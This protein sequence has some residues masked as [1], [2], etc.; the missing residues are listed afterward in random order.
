MFMMSDTPVVILAGGYGTRLSEY[1][2]KI[3]K[4]L[5][6]ANNKPLIWYIMAHYSKYGF[7]NF[8]ICLGYKGKYIKD[9]FETLFSNK[10]LK[11]ESKWNVKL[12]NTGINSLTGTRLKKIQKEIKTD[13]FLLTYGDG[14]SKINLKKLIQFHIKSKKLITFTAVRPP[15]RFGEVKFISNSN[16]IKSFEEKNKIDAGWINGG[17]FVI[18]KEFFSLIPSRD[19]MLE[20][21]PME[22]ALKSKKLG[23]FKYNGFWQCIDSKRDLDKFNELIKT[24]K[25]IIA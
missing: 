9:Y 10:K 23:A 4:P 21:F 12:I 1:T 16:E 20:K 24:K 6:K 3:P 7:N 8:I 19:V 5:V 11:K 13:Y 25:F 17:F 14:I 15:D 2:H 18:N 22:K